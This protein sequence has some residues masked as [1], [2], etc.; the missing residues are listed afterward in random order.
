MQD[1]ALT[2]VPKQKSYWRLIWTIIFVIL[3]IP[4]V[5]MLVFSEIIGGVIYIVSVLVSLLFTLY[6]IP[7]YYRSMKFFITGEE[8][9]V[10]K[11]VLL[12]KKTII[13]FERRMNMHITQNPFERHYKICKIHVKTPKAG[14]VIQGIKINTLDDVKREINDRIRVEKRKQYWFSSDT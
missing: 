8:V 3:M 10:E 11:G 12:N 5:I 2:P 14:G 1:I 4:G 13:P 9:I 7:L 6:W